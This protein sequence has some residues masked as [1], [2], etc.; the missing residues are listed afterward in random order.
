MKDDW[1]YKYSD[2]T[3]WFAIFGFWFISIVFVGLFT[4]FTIK[5]RN[6]YECR[7]YCNKITDS[8]IGYQQC[9]KERKI[10]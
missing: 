9:M 10:Q 4:A 7:D 6:C 3:V 2:S 5:D 1:D 8:Y